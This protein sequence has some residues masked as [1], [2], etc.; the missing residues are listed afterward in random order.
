MACE[1]CKN[2]GGGTLSTIKNRREL[3]IELR[4]RIASRV[5]EF[6]ANLIFWQRIV[7]TSKSNT[8]EIMEALGKV[9]LNKNNIKADQEFLKDI[10]KMLI[11]KGN[12]N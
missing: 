1:C 4:N 6:E 10:D 12:K 3:I 7:R 11:G 8:P 9:E 2:S 5:V